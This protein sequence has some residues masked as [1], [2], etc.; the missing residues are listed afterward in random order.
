[1]ALTGPLRANPKFSASLFA[2]NGES[3]D[4]QSGVV[5]TG[6]DRS[7]AAI[8]KRKRAEEAALEDDEEEDALEAFQTPKVS[9]TG[10]LWAVMALTGTRRVVSEW[11]VRLRLPRSDQRA[12]SASVPPKSPLVPRRPES[13]VVLPLVAVAVA[14]VLHVRTDASP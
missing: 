14:L 4:E 13:G 10:S 9:P 7:K 8:L 1:M 12:K 11:L 3:D 2:H 5:L 6:R